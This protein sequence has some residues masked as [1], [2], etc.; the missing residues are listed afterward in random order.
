MNNTIYFLDKQQK[1]T[2]T[3]KDFDYI[4]CLCL[5]IYTYYILKHGPSK[6]NSIEKKFKIIIGIIWVIFIISVIILSI[7]GNY[8]VSSLGECY[9][10]TFGEISHQVSLIIVGIIEV[11]CIIMIYKR[12]K[13]EEQK[14]SIEYN[15]LNKVF[16]LGIALVCFLVIS[17]VV[18]VVLLFY[19]DFF[20]INKLIV[21]SLHY[22][23]Y[24]SFLL[25]YFADW[26]YIKD[27]SPRN[28]KRNNVEMNKYFLEG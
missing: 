4:L 6:Q 11:I 23:Y 10:D 22:I 1:F 28:N 3:K 7:F 17:T 13:I 8:K 12:L 5:F 14:E 21:R 20:V 24:V 2:E 27:C 15:N 26:S 18:N 9:F 19:T 16:Y 25:V